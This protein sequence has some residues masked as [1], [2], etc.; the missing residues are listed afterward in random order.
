[1][2][3]GLLML[4]PEQMR[5]LDC[6]HKHLVI[7]GP[8]G[9]GKTIIALMK[10]ELLAGSLPESD[11]VYFIC[12]DS[13]SELSSEISGSSKIKIYHNNEGYN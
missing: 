3:D 6:Q 5:L 11:V 10:L 7:S 8:Y 13:K 12:F 1:M 2:K 9:S 4:T